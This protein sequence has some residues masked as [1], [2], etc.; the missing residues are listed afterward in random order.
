MKRILFVFC[1]LTLALFLLSACAKSEV[2]EGM[3]PAS[4]PDLDGFTLY[5]PKGYTIDRSTG[6]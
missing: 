4:D 1:F 2:P 5:V 6:S 3:T